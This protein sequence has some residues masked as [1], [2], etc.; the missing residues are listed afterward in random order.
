[1]V[2]LAISRRKKKEAHEN[3]ACCWPVW[4]GQG[5]VSAS[6][7]FM[8]TNGIPYDAA[9]AG[10]QNTSQSQVISNFVLSY[11]WMRCFIFVYFE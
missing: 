5:A 4:V 1:M 2:A 11:F 3:A 10:V 6:V 8:R 7:S 9:G